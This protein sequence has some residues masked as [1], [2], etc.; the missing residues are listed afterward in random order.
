MEMCWILLKGRTTS[1]PQTTSPGCTP[2][3]LKMKLN[4][5][6]LIPFVTIT[7]ANVSAHGIRRLHR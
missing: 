1:D 5:A 6:A 7:M 2:S 3:L 4:I